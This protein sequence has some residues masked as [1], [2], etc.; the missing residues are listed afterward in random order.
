MY[1]FV[2]SKYKKKKSYPEFKKSRKR[3]QRISKLTDY[4]ILSIKRSGVGSVARVRLYMLYN[5]Q[6]SYSYTDKWQSK[7]VDV[8]WH[9]VCEKGA[10]HIELP[11]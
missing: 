2:D 9:M 1:F 11:Q 6:T 4:E 5:P 10:W 8:E 7:T 3:M